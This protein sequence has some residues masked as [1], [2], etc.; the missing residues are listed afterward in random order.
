MALAEL[1][2]LFADTVTRHN[3]FWTFEVLMDEERRMGVRSTLFFLYETSEVEITNPASW[4]HFGRRYD[5]RDSGISSVM[6]ELEQGG[7]EVGLHGSFN[8]FNHCDSLKAEK[9]LLEQVVG[10]KVAGVRQ[11]NL[12][13]EIPESWM[14]QDSLGFEY[15]S[16]LGFRSREGVGY[17][18]GTCLPFHP[19]NS[20]GEVM[21]LLEIPMTLMD[22]SLDKSNIGVNRKEIAGM[23]DEVSSLRGVFCI[24]WHHVFFN[25]RDYP[26]WVEL[27]RWIVREC[28]RKGGIFLTLREAAELWKQR[29]Q[30]RLWVRYDGYG[31]GK[32]RVGS[33]YPHLQIFTPGGDAYQRCSNVSCGDGSVLSL[34]RVKI[35]NLRGFY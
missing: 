16:S 13:L 2:F 9:E 33:E 32:I 8:S 20:S 31:G 18:W 5:F 6:H 17:R 10:K 7:W 11:H 27:Y 12:N 23:I 25:S 35:C 15:D 26:E 14:C 19:L 29:E 34:D 21:R 1:K 3:P 28:R 30:G 24:L 4:K 22:V